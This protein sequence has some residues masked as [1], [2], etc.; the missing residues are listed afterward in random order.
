ME[1]KGTGGISCG[2]DDENFER[3]WM[4]TYRKGTT[5]YDEIFCELLLKVTAQ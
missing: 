5:A 3:Q 1:R 4:L 2:F